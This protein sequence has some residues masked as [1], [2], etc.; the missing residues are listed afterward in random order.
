MFTSISPVILEPL[1]TCRFAKFNL[2]LRHLKSNDRWD[3]KVI[4]VHAQS[5]TK[6]YLSLFTLDPILPAPLTSSLIEVWT[7]SK[8]IVTLRTICTV[9]ATLQRRTAVTFPV[10][11][12]VSFANIRAA[13]VNAL[14]LA[15]FQAESIVL[16]RVPFVARSGCLFLRE[17]I[18]V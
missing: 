14:L 13:R 2:P 4:S 15:A 5:P 8:T 11:D 9:K 18:S 12:A 16:L 17:S 10:E 7:Q 3:G 1:R 6:P